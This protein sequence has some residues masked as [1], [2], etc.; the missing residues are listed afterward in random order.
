M[1]SILNFVFIIVLY[2][3]WWTKQDHIYIYFEEFLNQ[4]YLFYIWIYLY[5]QQIKIYEHMS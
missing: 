1:I 2:T 5:L 4:F 3:T